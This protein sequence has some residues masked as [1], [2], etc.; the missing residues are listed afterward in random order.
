MKTNGYVS[1]TDGPSAHKIYVVSYATNNQSAARHKQSSL[2]LLPG[3]AAGFW[4][5]E[6]TERTRLI[7]SSVT[8]SSPFE[9]LI[10]PFGLKNAP[11]IYQRMM[12]NALYGLLKI[13]AR[14][15]IITTGY[16]NLNDVF[17]ELE[18]DPDPIPSVL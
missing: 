6:M 11:Q 17:T 15:D 8:P 9:W 2:A 18:P 3:M 5:V 14:S 10:M 13:L 12:D 7:S 4:V 16:P 1:I